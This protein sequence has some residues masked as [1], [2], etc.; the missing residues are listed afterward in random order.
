M[1]T[2]RKSIKKAAVG[3][4]KLGIKMGVHVLPVH[5]Y[6]PVP[7]IVALKRD[8]SSWAQAS[9]M[10]GIHVDLDAQLDW[11]AQACQPHQFE[12]KGNQVYLDGQARHF[13]PG[14][15]YIEAQALH[16]VVRHLKPPRIVEVGSGVSTWCMAHAL[17]LN[18]DRDARPGRITSIEPHPS[19]ALQAM[20]GIDLVAQPVQRTPMSVFTDLTA[21]DMLFIDSSHTVRPG[22]DVNF[23][24]LEVL[25][26]LQPGVVI[27]IHDIYLPYDYQRDVCDT[28]FHW[29]ETSLVRAWMTHNPKVKILACLSHLHYARAAGMQKV[30]PEY[31]PQENEHGMQPARFDVTNPPPGHFPCSLYLQT[32]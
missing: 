24:V 18:A 27:H 13:G 20:A 30:F 9:E 14:Y 10:P 19:A 32:C 15:G 8:P 12:F 28:F 7:N 4:H 22:G 6:S 31:Q 25:P 16:G 21:G 17:K 26:R 5:Y 29:T 1:A 11:L 23:L 3:V 2:L